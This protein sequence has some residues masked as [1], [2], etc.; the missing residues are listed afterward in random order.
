MSEDK[1]LRQEIDDLL[2]FSLTD[3]ELNGLVDFILNDRKRIVA[4]L[5]KWA[6]YCAWGT[7]SSSEGV[8]EIDKYIRKSLKLAGVA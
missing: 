6:K 5:V 2:T 8:E 1:K 3:H 4:P 7:D